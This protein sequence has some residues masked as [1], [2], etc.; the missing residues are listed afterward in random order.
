MKNVHIA[1]IEDIQI[2]GIDYALITLHDRDDV[3]GRIVVTVADGIAISN[4]L[5]GSKAAMARA[6]K[7]ALALLNSIADTGVQYWY[8]CIGTE[9][10]WNKGAC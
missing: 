5:N 7:A 4:S 10:M 1:Q 6:V 2:N 3:Y 8:Y 9:H